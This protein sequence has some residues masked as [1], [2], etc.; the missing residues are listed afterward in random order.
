[1]GDDRYVAGMAV[2][3]AVLGAEHVER[4]TAAASPFDA[5]F[6]RFITEAAWGSVWTRAGL[7]RR[8]RSLVTL[9]ILATRG[10]WEEFRLHVRAMVN[11]G[12]TAAEL[13][14]VLRHVAASAGLPTAARGRQVLREEEARATVG[15]AGS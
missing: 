11:T 15:S 10:C 6:Q 12:A 8:T 1:M 13:D 4:A 7:D 3:R 14:E 9:A 5:P 2:R